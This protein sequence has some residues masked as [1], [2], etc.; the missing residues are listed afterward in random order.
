MLIS[1]GLPRFFVVVTSMFLPT[2]SRLHTTTMYV[3]WLFFIIGKLIFSS[4]SLSLFLPSL[5]AQLPWHIP[6]VLVADVNATIF[7]VTCYNR[8]WWTVKH[9]KNSRTNTHRSTIDDTPSYGTMARQQ[10]QLRSSTGVENGWI[11]EEKWGCR[12]NNKSHR[13]TLVT[14]LYTYFIF[15]KKKRSIVY[16]LWMIRARFVL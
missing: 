3:C 4:S 8:W 13:I 12:R 5:G 7:L 6:D 11:N 10:Q 9:F 1:H 15:Y 14:I 16:F 2:P